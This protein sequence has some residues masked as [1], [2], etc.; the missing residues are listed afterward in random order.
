[1]DFHILIKRKRKGFDFSAR[2][3]W[4][5]MRE[6]GKIEVRNSLCFPTGSGTQGVS[7]ECECNQIVVIFIMVDKSN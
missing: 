5:L 4:N 6:E 7:Y 2:D 1:M 3:E